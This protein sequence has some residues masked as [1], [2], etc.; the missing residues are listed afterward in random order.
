M[1]CGKSLSS[2][3][4]LNFGT[5]LNTMMSLSAYHSQPI[6]N[7]GLSIEDALNGRGA[8]QSLVN[9]IQQGQICIKMMATAHDIKDVSDRSCKNDGVSHGEL[10]WSKYR[11]EGIGERALLRLTV[12]NT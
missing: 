11:E 1:K 8:Q 5:L 3:Q 12:T 6:E 2:I 9:Y 7:K 10:A 4:L